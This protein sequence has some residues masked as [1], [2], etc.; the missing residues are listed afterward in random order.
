MMSLH[1]IY[2]DDV[3]CSGVIRSE[4][5]GRADRAG[6]AVPSRGSALAGFMGLACSC[7]L[8]GSTDPACPLAVTGGAD[9]A[10]PLAVTGGADPACPLAVTG[11]A[12]PAGGADRAQGGSGR[13]A[14]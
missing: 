9:P 10:C 6:C 3:I 14:G 2:D 1:C 13:G 5:A 8:A 12:D 11:G 4:P 7:G